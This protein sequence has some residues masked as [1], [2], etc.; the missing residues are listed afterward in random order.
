MSKPLSE[1]LEDLSAEVRGGLDVEAD[2]LLILAD[3]AAELETAL[4]WLAETRTQGG[5]PAEWDHSPLPCAGEGICMYDRVDR[6]TKCW[7][8]TAL[9]PAEEDGD[10]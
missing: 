2:D 6:D 1:M 10:E 5:C 9:K 4:E 7:F 3:R 8:D